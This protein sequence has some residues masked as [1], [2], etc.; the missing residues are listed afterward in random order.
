MAKNFGRTRVYVEMQ[1]VIREDTL[2]VLQNLKRKMTKSDLEFV[3]AIW[4][5]I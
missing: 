2:S 3:V 5:V 4:W 1:G